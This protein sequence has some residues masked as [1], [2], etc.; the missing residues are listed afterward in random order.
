MR[1]PTL[2]LA[3]AVLAPLTACDDGVR[4]DYGGTKERLVWKGCKDEVVREIDCDAV[5]CHCR[6][7]GKE[8]RAFKGTSWPWADRM[9]ATRYANESCGWNLSRS[10][11]PF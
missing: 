1:I 2:L 10:T 3:L 7:D 9:A 6:L 11:L 8:S 4:C 5:T